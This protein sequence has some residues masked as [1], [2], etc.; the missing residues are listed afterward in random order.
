VIETIIERD[1]SD[2]DGKVTHVAKVRNPHVA[3]RML[4][5]EDQLSLRTKQRTPCDVRRGFSVRRALG[6]SSGCRRRSSSETPVG[7]IRRPLHRVG[8][9][10]LFQT[11]FSGSGRRLPRG[12]F[13]CKGRR[14]RSPADRRSTG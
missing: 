11:S 5:A 13:F 14:G 12:A 1:A 4:L 7:L 10:S 8:T 9:T 6:L 2:A 3:R